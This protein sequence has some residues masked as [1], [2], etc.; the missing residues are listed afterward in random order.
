MAYNEKID[1]R[2][3]EAKENFCQKRFRLEERITNDIECYNKFRDNTS[4]E[5]VIEDCQKLIALNEY[6]RQCIQN[7][8]NLKSPVTKW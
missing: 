2:I 1:E 6:E 8:E 3:S 7:M 5:W 4:L